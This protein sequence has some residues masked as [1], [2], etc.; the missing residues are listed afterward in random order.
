MESCQFTVLP[1][2][3]DRGPLV[4]DLKI[5]IW[6]VLFNFQFSDHSR[7]IHNLDRLT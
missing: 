1:I 7:L 3:G 5:E 4:N 2:R 6:I